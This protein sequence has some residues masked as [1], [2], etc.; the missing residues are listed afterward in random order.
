MLE[1]AKRVS[2]A[3][4]FSSRVDLLDGRHLRIFLITLSFGV[5]CLW[6]LSRHGQLLHVV[7]AEAFVVIVEQIRNVLQIWFEGRFR[8]K[9]STTFLLLQTQI[10]YSLAAIQKVC[11]GKLRADNFFTVILAEGYR[12]V[13]LRTEAMVEREFIHMSW[14]KNF[15]ESW[16]IYCFC[17]PVALCERGWSF[18]EELLVPRELTRSWLG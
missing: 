5:F 13:D 12:R 11:L 16:S 4:I 2:C 14:I 8:P 10:S 7:K 15:G 1:G 17:L 18:R 6:F 3:T 9:F